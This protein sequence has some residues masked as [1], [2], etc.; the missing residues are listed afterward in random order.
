MNKEGV[1]TGRFA[2]NPYNGEKV[3]IWL[4][5]F[6][7]MDYGTG[8]IMAVPAHDQRD[9][10]FCQKYG[11][12]IRPVIRPVDGEL[13][14]AATLAE[15]FPDYGILENS[16]PF[17]GLP[18]AEAIEKMNAF[19]TGKG[20]AEAAITYRLKDWGISRQRYWGTPIPMIHCPQC[21]VVPVPVD[22][23][24]VLLPANIE[25]TGTG[26]SPLRTVRVFV[27]VECP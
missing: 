11:I 20:F 9:F 4:G 7:L 3:P 26:E 15:A 6:V 14:D 16:G 17:T 1:A 18:S 2:I 5:N 19:G 12:P 25:L 24:P 22:Q 27:N 23:L 21:G 10:E 8:A 13:A